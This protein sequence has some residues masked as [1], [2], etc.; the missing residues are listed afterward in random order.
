MDSNKQKM[1]LK[2]QSAFGFMGDLSKAGPRLNVGV[3]GATGVVGSKL[4]QVLRERR[5]PI[6]EL[7]L[8]ASPNSAGKWIMTPFDQLCI[9]SL[10][11]RKVPHHDLVFMAA[12]SAV[13]R[14][15]GLR[16]ARRG[17]L[18]IDKSAY[19]RNKTYAPLVV[20]EVNADSLENNSGIIANPNCTTIPLVTALAPLHEEFILKTIT[21]VSFQSVSGSGN[22]GMVALT[23]ELFDKEVEPTAFPHR[24]AH[25]VIPWIGSNRN[26]FSEEELKMVTETRKILQ[27]TRLP[28]RITAV[29]VPVVVGHS[30]AVHASFRSGVETEKARERLR[31]SPGI[32]IVDDPENDQYPTPLQAAGRNDVLVGRVRRDRIQRGLAFWISCD[33]LRKGAATNA[34]QIAEELLDRKLIRKSN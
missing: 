28:I 19:F 15:W 3:V 25:N 18:V 9:E 17:A 30:M 12:G 7:H 27:L 1:D 13:A 10:S 4:L 29:R 6:G 8:Y 2:D 32:T 16:F 5:F 34:V 23:N 21:A 20:P 22:K 26:G 31:G 14:K 11:T 33:N 24:I